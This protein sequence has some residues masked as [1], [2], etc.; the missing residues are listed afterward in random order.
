MAQMQAGSWKRRGI[1]EKF[2]LLHPE[3]A[4]FFDGVKLFY[5]TCRTWTKHTNYES[6]RII[7]NLSF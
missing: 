5:E 6:Y 4:Y 1:L 2:T 7:F 3:C